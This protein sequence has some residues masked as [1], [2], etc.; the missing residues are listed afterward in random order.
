M[1][2]AGGAIYCVDTSSL[3]HAWRRAYPPKRFPAVWRQLEALIEAGR[4]LASIEV[5]NELRRKDDDL[6]EW[7]KARKE[8]LFREIDEDV[9]VHVIRLMRTYPKLVD[10][11]KGKSG[12]DPFVIA[13]AVAASPTLIVVTQEAGGSEQSPKIPFVC[14]REGVRCIDLL[15]LI[16]EEDWTF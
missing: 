5:Y 11:A 14:A 13:Q 10:T 1:A 4:L 16:D 6:F 7:A 15:T 12:G 2:G 9:Q 8:A 3:M